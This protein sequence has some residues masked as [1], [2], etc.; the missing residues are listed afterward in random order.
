MTLIEFDSRQMCWLYIICRR[1]RS[2]VWLWQQ[3]VSTSCARDFLPIVFVV[4]VRRSVAVSRRPSEFSVRLWICVRLGW[5]ADRR[6]QGLNQAGTRRNAVPGPVNLSLERSGC[7]IIWFHSRNV[8]SWAQQVS[9]LRY[10]NPTVNKSFKF[11][12]LTI[13]N[14]HCWMFFTKF[15]KIAKKHYEN[16]A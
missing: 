9:N 13:I 10:S 14:S 11:H 8:R 15:Y 2:V 4:R 7:K 3:L 12:I 5:S 1:R 6:Q 16:H